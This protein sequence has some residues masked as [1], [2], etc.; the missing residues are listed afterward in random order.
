MSLAAET[1]RA[2]ER[3]PFLVAALRAEVVN[4]TAAARFLDV[5][6]ELEAVATALRRYAEDLPDYETDARDA[7]VTMQSGLGPVETLEEALIVVGAGALGV[8]ETGATG[9][10]RTAILANGAVDASALSSV[11]ERLAL[12]EIEVESAA[13][14]D[15]TLAVVV[16]RRDGVNAVR[17]VEG[18]LESVPS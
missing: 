9:G 16:G 7:R 17:L 12:A 2:L 11:L 1:R 8:P 5:D 3:H 13:V 4:Y 18:A 15:G 6:G 10:D 14:A